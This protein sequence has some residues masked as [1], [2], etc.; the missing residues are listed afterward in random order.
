METCVPLALLLN[1]TVGFICS[2]IPDTFI[3]VIAIDID[4][5]K[6]ELAKHN[7]AI[8]KVAD[9]IEFIVGD[10]FE[11]APTLKADVVFLSPPWGG[12]DYNRSNSFPLNKILKPYGGELL[13]QVARNISEHVAYYL[14]RNVNVDQVSMFGH[15]LH[16]RGTRCVTPSKRH[17][18]AP[19]LKSTSIPKNFECEIE[20][21]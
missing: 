18:V 7:A 3:P 10:F 4:P 9:R 11:L 12:P 14:P 15:V 19:N 17:I 2:N 8:Y 20:K 16:C 21:L 5:Q 6:I 13:Y 1:I